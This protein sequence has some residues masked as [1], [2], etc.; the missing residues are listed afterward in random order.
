M[1]ESYRATNGLGQQNLVQYC[2][3]A[4]R[5]VLCQ[6][7]ETEEEVKLVVIVEFLNPVTTRRCR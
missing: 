7:S 5:P 6:P 2:C 1:V 3:L 4:S